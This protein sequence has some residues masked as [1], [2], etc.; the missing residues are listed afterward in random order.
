MRFTLLA[1]VLFALT[2][3]AAPVSDCES[4]KSLAV[5]NG[6]KLFCAEKFPVA[7]NAAIAPVAGK[8]KNNAKRFKEDDDRVVRVLGSMP[9][10]RQKAFCACYPAVASSSVAN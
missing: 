5:L 6:A 7:A 4:L 3:L 2:S 1:P 9:E 8:P 10:S